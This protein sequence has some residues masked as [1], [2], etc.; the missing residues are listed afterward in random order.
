MSVVGR[1]CSSWSSSVSPLTSLHRR[2][3]ILEPPFVP[4][5]GG[6]LLRLH[7]VGVDV[8]AGE[9]VFGRDQV[10]R[11]ALRHEIG[12]NRERRIDRPGAARRR[13]S[14]RGSSTSTPPP[15]VRSCWPAITCAAAKLTASRPEAQK[16]L[17]C[18]PGTLSPKPAASAPMRAMSPPL[19][20]PDRRSPCTTSSTLPGS[21]SLRS[22]IA[23]SAGRGKMQRR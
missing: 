2:D 3:R 1:M 18:T 4:G 15:I 19:R 23:F 21:S 20:R 16:R 11:D 13:R 5:G 17:I 12:G 14:R 6:A 9:A 7:G 8:V 10:G 22:L